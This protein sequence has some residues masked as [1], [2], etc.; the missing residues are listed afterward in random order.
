MTIA[1]STAR[2]DYAGDNV[3]T[4]F[5]VP[6]YF[7]EPT[8]LRVIRRAADGTETLL[9]KDIHYTVAG[10]GSPEGGSITMSSAPASGT[11]IAILRNVPATQT[12]DY[13]ANDPFPADS[14][15]RGLDKLTMIV[16]QQGEE[17]GRSL[18]VPVTDAAL[19]VLP[20]LADRAGRLLAFSGAG[21][22]VAGPLVS[23]LISLLATASSPALAQ[24]GANVS[25][26]ADSA[27]AAPRSIEDKARERVS[28]L[29]YI[30]DATVP[31]LS[32]RNGT[33]SA[34]LAPYVQKALDDGGRIFVP[35]GVYRLESQLDGGSDTELYGPGTLLAAH[36]GRIIEFNGKSNCGL[37]GLTLDGN[38][39]A[40]M[41]AYFISCTDPFASGCR[42]K[43]TA[44]SGENFRGGILFAL[45]TDPVLENCRFNNISVSNNQTRAMSFTQCTGGRVSHLR[46][47]DVGKFLH[48]GNSTDFT[49]TDCVGH[50]ISDNGLY[51][52]DATKRAYFA[53]LE[54]N[55][56]GEGIVLNLTEGGLTQYDSQIEIVGFIVRGATTRAVTLRDGAGFRLANGI[57]VGGVNGIAQ[58]SSFPGCRDFEIDGFR[59]SGTTGI[60]LAFNLANSDVHVRG[61][62]IRDERVGVGTVAVTVAQ[63]CNRIYF[64]APVIMVGGDVTTAIQYAAGASSPRTGGV[65]GLVTNAATRVSTP[66]DGTQTGIVVDDPHAG[67]LVNGNWSVRQHS[68][69]AV[70]LI[71]VGSRKT[72]VG[73]GD[74]LARFALY[75]SDT[76]LSNLPALTYTGDGAETT[77]AAGRSLIDEYDVEVRVAGVIQNPAAYSVSGSN[78]VFGSAPADGAAISIQ[79]TSRRRFFELR[80]RSTSATGAAHAVDVLCDGVVVGT[81]LPGGLSPKLPTSAAGL[82]SGSLWN[83]AG[84]PA[85]V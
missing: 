77:F 11:Q 17:V 47:R 81:I 15:E 75:S 76:S 58:S 72:S 79:P 50:N 9:T 51:L 62:N 56:V 84:T 37:R 59:V 32:I 40:D 2:A 18:R 41:G 73:D 6:F 25:Y 20:K 48:F 60:P 23:A 35:K 10:A 83:N 27:F 16:Q 4:V 36:A 39:A 31:H 85:I 33:N 74:V 19:P 63:T 66:S 61:L 21:A 28:L 67:L 43:D 68:D 64:H 44:D 45:C 69:H 53:G 54:F 13:V 30:P 57:A 70:P 22:P 55:V 52:I 49:C 24:S 78:V 7:L 12:L 71:E 5:T 42:V 46:A 1:T 3:S 80:G 8:H 29:D 26:V 38:N 82:P 34:D 14:H 65:S